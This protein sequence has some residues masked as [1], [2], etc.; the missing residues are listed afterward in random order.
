MKFLPKTNTKKDRKQSFQKWEFV[1]EQSGL[2]LAVQFFIAI[3][4]G[5]YFLKITLIPLLEASRWF[6]TFGLFGFFV[7]YFLKERL[8][9][10]LSDALLYS[11]FV[12][13]PWIMAILLGFNSLDS[14]VYTETY[15]VKHADQFMDRFDFE[16]EDEMYQEFW[17]IRSMQIESRPA[18][19]T[20]VTYTF[21][22]GLL[23]YKVVKEIN[24]N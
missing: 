18:R 11:V 21:C 5:T 10:S 14:Q 3:A 8:S 24:L 4:I 6:I 20:Y 1:G 17:R 16:L 22:D 9:L 2:I 23:G 15:L 7:T 19:S 13:A 12:T